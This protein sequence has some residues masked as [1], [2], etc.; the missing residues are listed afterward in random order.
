M[1]KIGKWSF[2]EGSSDA[3]RKIHASIQRIPSP[4]FSYNV[5]N[6]YVMGSLELRQLLLFQLLQV[7]RSKKFKHQFLVYVSMHEDDDLVRCFVKVHS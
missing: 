5:V 3:D 6:S 1:E 2:F 4:N 7:S